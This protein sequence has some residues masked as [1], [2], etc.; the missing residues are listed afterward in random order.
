MIGG[1]ALMQLERLGQ[2][3]AERLVIGIGAYAANCAAHQLGHGLRVEGGLAV[4][5]QGEH[6][7]ICGSGD[8][9][10]RSK[11]K[12]EAAIAI[13]AAGAD[14]VRRLRGRSQQ[15]RRPDQADSVRSTGQAEYSLQTL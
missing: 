6:A 9:T 8:M 2:S 14:A 3:K 10:G 1:R 5:G 4:K 7:A 13:L 12:V 15:Q 11:N